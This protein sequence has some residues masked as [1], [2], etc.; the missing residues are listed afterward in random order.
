MQ[1]FKFIPNEVREPY[2]NDAACGPSIHPSDVSRALKTVGLP[3]SARDKLK[4]V[5][6]VLISLL[7][8]ACLSCSKPTNS[9]TVVVLIEFSPN[10]LDPRV[11][12]DAQS[13]R[14]D[15][16][17]FDSLVRKDDHFHLLPSVAERWETPD[18]Q[19]YIFHIRHGIR[20]HDGRPLTARDVKWT[21]DTLLNHSLKTPKATTYA[22][23][24]KIDTPDDFTLTLHLREP[25]AALLWNLSDAAFG[26]VP[27][28][29]GPE[30]N[31]NPIGSGPFKFV[32]FDI[33]NQVI[34]E[35]NDSYWGEHARVRR[36]RFAVVPDA[37]TRVLE[38]RKGSADFASNALPLDMVAALKNEKELELMKTPGTILMYLAFNLRDPILQDVRVRQALAYA[39]DRGSLL[40][41]L[42]RD[43]GR[44]ADSV[45]PPEHW[46]YNGNVAHYPFDPAKA[47]AVLDAAG[48][49]R[50]QDGV[51]FHLT[52]KTSI[53]EAPR[54][55]AAV[56]QQQLRE[57]GIALDIRSFEFAT[58]MS[59]VEKGAFQ[60]YSLRLIGGNQD[61]DVFEGFFYSHSFPPNRYNRER[62]SNPQVDRLI[63]EGRS[64]L[65]QQTRQQV[66]GE[67]QRILANDLPF[68]DL[69]YLD[70]V[71]VHS[72]RTTNIEMNPS[73]NYDFLLH[74]ELK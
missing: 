53:D 25:N 15:E 10:N 43:A 32:R 44:L 61:P 72:T 46:A 41:Y 37:T 51:R 27:Y 12:I 71:M 45:L 20:F 63:E 56:L 5:S 74:T 73:G 65:N 34:I 28:G 50:G 1:V 17:L 22:L 14:I 40:H 29:S 19:T 58:F 39:I 49:R 3:R 6:V 47:N 70:N 2:S 21:L 11:G 4:N 16:L 18:P 7:C 31:L 59:D 23:L 36:V 68:I 52:M 67:I 48:Y 33:D 42:F 60:L 9:D 35:R 13:E 30:F 24:D 66:Y 62:Y 55:I 8:L 38:L 57:V 69:W 26:I 64:T 54:L